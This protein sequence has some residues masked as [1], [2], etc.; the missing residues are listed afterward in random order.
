[1]KRILYYLS[2][3]ILW[4]IT[5]LPLRI[6]Y[7]VSDFLYLILYYLVG[8]RKKT[9]YQNLQHSLPGKSPKELRQIARKFY[10]H[11]CDY[12]IESVYLIH[13]SEKENARRIH[14]I[15]AA[16]LQDYYKQGTSLIL[17]VS[18]YGNWE[19]PNRITRLSSHSLLGIYKPLQNKYFDRFFVQLRGQF[20]G[21]A[22]PMESTLRTMVTYQRDNKPCILYTVADQRPQWT[23]IQ[24]WTTFLNQDTPV[25]T[26]PE[27]IARRFNIPVYFLD[28]QKIKRGNY[29]AEFKLL[30]EHPAEEPE[31]QIIRRYQAMVEKK[32]LQQPEFWLWSH[33]RWKYYRHE[34][35]DPVYIG[36][37]P[38][39]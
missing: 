39:D 6:L 21:I 7:L 24:Y 20:G 14:Y 19:W 37:L 16:F 25:I 30:S 36:D 9:V 18:H 10:S 17:L 11:L 28:I 23:S 38:K 2:Y 15:N 4:L 35:K 32:I 13:M 27:K 22:I 1:M 33:K 8:Y 31:F 12:F 26:G 3:S 5:L 29:S 34:A